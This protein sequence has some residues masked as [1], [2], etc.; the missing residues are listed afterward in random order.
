MSSEFL[1]SGRRL[2]TDRPAFSGKRSN[3]AGL[4]SQISGNHLGRSQ[5][6]GGP[7]PTLQKVVADCGPRPTLQQAGRLLPVSTLIAIGAVG[8]VIVAGFLPSAF[9]IEAPHWE[10]PSFSI[11][12]TTQCHTLHASP[13]GGLTS[14][15]SNVNLCQSCHSSSGLAD[16]A[17][18]PNSAAAIP[19]F[20]GTSHAFAV[21]ALHATYSTQLPEQQAMALRIM[22]DNV[23]C[24]TC[25]NQHS[26]TSAEGGTPKISVP[27]KVTDLTGSGT[28]ASQGTFNGALGVWYMLEIDGA[29]SQ[30][31]ATFRWSKDNGISWIAETEPVGNGSPVTLDSGV[32]VIFSGAAGDAYF[33]GEQW[34]LF[35]SYPF[36]RVKLDSGDLNSVDKFCRDCH[37]DWV[38]THG[39]VETWDGTPKSHPV[40]IGLNANVQGYDRAQPLDGNGVIQAAGSSPDVDGNPS[41]DL[42][43]DS[44]G[45]VQCLSCHGVHYADSNTLSVDQP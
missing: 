21:P 17:P 4:P 14:D 3:V 9:A 18:I 15:A 1:L 44:L 45:N 29:G 26:A 28:V 27:E 25:H 43:L 16:R 40:G 39:D 5:A 42:K 2:V 22:N 41:N 23:V 7:R 32:E 36:L 19:G 13:G 24:S 10:S 11:D 30:A 31:T 37:R 34:E 33:V 12:C 35:G 20:G 8:A 38:M 6:N